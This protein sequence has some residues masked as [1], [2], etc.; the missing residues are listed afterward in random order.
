MNKNLFPVLMSVVALGTSAQAK[1]KMEVYDFQ[2]FKLHVYYTND[3]L[4]DASYIVEGSD[5]LV[6]LEQPLFRDN[7]AEYN[8]YLDS[9]GKPV[10]QR[11]ADYHL[12]GTDHHDITMAE[13]MPAFTKGAVYGG[14]MEH[15]A[16]VFGDAITDLPTGEQTEVAFG[17]TQQWAGITFRFLQGAATDFPGASLLIGDKVYYTHW[18]PAKAH[19]SPLQIGSCE[20][21]DAEIAEAER[22]LELGAILF[23]GGHGG[24]ADAET[25]RFK[26]QYLRTLKQLLSEHSTPESLVAAMQKTYPDLPGADNLTDLAKALVK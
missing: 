18:V 4:G 16:Q 1:G 7:I 2:S 15:F 6:T 25:V 12:G 10:A 19:V 13:G 23:I 9:L 8:A 17:S 26:I 22:S 5:A 21:I 24:A 14:M 20:A 11:I 3:A